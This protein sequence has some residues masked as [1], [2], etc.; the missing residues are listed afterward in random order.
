MSFQ[1]QC[2]ELQEKIAKKNSLEVQKEELKKQ[3]RDLENKVFNLELQRDAEQRDVE[4]MEARSLAAL[5]YKLIGRHEERLD[6]ERQEAYTA[7]V[8]CDAAVRELAAVRLNLD[9]VLGQMGDVRGCEEAYRK[10]LETRKEELKAEAGAAADQ[11]IALEEKAAYLKRQKHEIGE[12]VA[13]G[14]S[15]LVLA[16]AVAEKLD[17]AEGWGTWDL[18]GGGLI[19]DLAKHSALDEAQEKIEELQIRLRKFQTELADVRVSAQLQVNVEGFLRFADYFFDGLIADW[20]VLN[21]IQESSAEV[22]QVISKLKDSLRHL[23]QM[24]MQTESQTRECGW[25]L[26]ELIKSIG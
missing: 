12:A 14:R 5:F 20:T 18:V 10:L 16:E 2:R 11:I 21:K 3:E 26:D 1:E 4:R 7:A 15:A 6:K 25:E 9:E 22:N 8:K 19:A 24:R 13:A 17:S 23:E